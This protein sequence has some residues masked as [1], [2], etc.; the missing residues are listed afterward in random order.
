MEIIIYIL[1]CITF[2]V[3]GWIIY[4][5]SAGPKKERITICCAW[6]VALAIITFIQM[7]T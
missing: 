5:A 3:C 6:A 7:F 2:C 4:N 1:Y